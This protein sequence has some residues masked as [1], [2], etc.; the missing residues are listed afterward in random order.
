MKRALRVVGQFSRRRLVA[1]LLVVGL[2]L[3]D[4]NWAGAATAD[5]TA[6]STTIFRSVGEVPG[7]S[8]TAIAQDG[9]GY[10]WVGGQSGL[11]RYDGYRFRAY[12]ADPQSPD[13]IHD[14]NINVLHTDRRGRLWIGTSVGGL[15]RYDP[16]GDRFVSYRAGVHGLSSD[17]VGS[18][19]DDAGGVWIGSSAGLDY[20]SDASGDFTH[21]HHDRRPGALPDDAISAL[22]VDD[23]GTLWVGTGSGLV[24]RDAAS[25]HFVPVALPTAAGKVPVAASIIEDSVGRIWIGTDENGLFVMRRSE[26]AAHAAQVGSALSR[27]EHCRDERS[28]P[29]PHVDRHG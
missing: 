11:S 16:A 21:F 2:S 12:R 25:G 1:V 13:A 19:A 28:S 20:R 8:V 10:L 9:A 23:A 6:L 24:R 14:T 17:S 4:L 15:A 5:W 18:L 27:N 3:G 29:G 7:T 26:R 22:F